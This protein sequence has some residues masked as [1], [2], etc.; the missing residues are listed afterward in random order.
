[1]PSS[2]RRDV[3]VLFADISG[4]TAM[5]ERLDPEA[6]TDFMNLCFADLE[7]VVL[8]HGGVVDKFI[9]DCVLAVFPR[10]RMAARA[11]RAAVEMRSA[12][13]A[14]NVQ[15]TL[16]AP[17]DV[18]IGIA[19]G[20]VIV[21]EIGG[22]RAR[23][24]TVSG[25][26]VARADRLQH[27]A[28]RGEI[29]LCPRTRAETEYEPS[30]GVSADM[31]SLG[32]LSPAPPGARRPSE[33]RQATVLFA[34]V[35]GLE[36]LQPPRPPDE[37]TAL[38][39]RCF[40]LADT[41]VHAYGGVV[42]KYIGG[43]VM[44]LF[45]VPNAIEHAPR[46]AI[47]AAIEM[48]R[49][50]D[51]LRAEL[52]TLSVRIGINTGLVIA[53]EIG[54]RQRRDFT[55]MGDTVNL[56]SRLKDA[57]GE[58]AILVGPETERATGTEFE[59][60]SPLPLKLKGKERP[61]AVHELNSA[62]ERVHRARAAPVG[63]HSTL[64]GRER[65]LAELEGVVAR[66]RAGHGGIVSVIGEAGLGKSRLVAE[67]GALEAKHDV[68]VLEG[69]CVSVGQGLSFHPFVD[70]LRHWARIDD[71]AEDAVAAE[72]LEAAVQRLLPEEVDDVFPFLATLMGIRPGGHHASRIDGLEGEAMEEMIFRSVRRLLERLAA[73]RPLLVLFEDLHWA[74]LS[75]VKLLE[76]LLRLVP[77]H[78]LLFTCVGRPDFPDT[79]GRI[80][81]AARDEYRDRY[82]E[83]VLARLTEPQCAAIVENLLGMDDLPQSTRALIIRK[84][85]G[86]PF[87]LEEVIRSL[88][89]QG[90]LAFRDGRYHRTEKIDSVVIPETIQEV[91]L[92][93]VDRLDEPTR[94]VLQLASVI[95][96][97]FQ[98]RILIAILG[99]E[100]DVD[101]RLAELTERRLLSVMES[102]RTA[103]LRRVRLHPERE[104]VFTHALLQETIYGAILQRTRRQL[105]AQVAR[106]TEEEFADR[107]VDFY[108]ML[109][110]HYSRAEH[111]EKAEEY[112]FKAGE[113][114]ARAAASTESL[115]FFREASRLYFTMHGEGGDPKKKALLE[116]SIGLA[117]LNHGDLTESIEH[118]DQAL[119]H[120]GERVPRGRATAAAYFARDLIGLLGQ[121]YVRTPRQREVADWDLEREVFQ[122][123]FNRGRAEITSDP[124][125]LFFDMVGGFRRINRIDARQ[126]DQAS[127]M[128]ASAATV[129]CY[130]GLSF[131]VSARALDIARRLIRPG[132]VRDTF[133]VASMDF[134]HHYLLGD[135]NDAH[136]ID[137]ELVEEAIRHGQLWDVNTYLGLHCDRL[138]RQGDFPR[139]R[140][141]LD[142]LHELDSAFGYTFAGANRD[143]MTA[144]VLTEERRLD[145][146][147]AAIDVYTEGRHEDALRVLGLG[148]R[149][150][151][152]ILSGDSRGAATSLAAAEKITTRSR[153]VPPWHLSA[154]AAA[155][156]R[157]DLA[158]LDEAR[159]FMPLRQQARRSMRYALRIA[160]SVAVQRTEIEQLA[161]RVLWS[162]GRRRSAFK[163]WQRAIATGE[164]LGARP[165]LART[166]AAIARALDA[167]TG[168]TFDG[169]DAAQ[170]LERARE[171][172]AGAGLA[173]DLEQE[174]AA[175]RA[176]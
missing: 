117:L 31:P 149:A 136:V 83:L 139:A 100:E 103:S 106:A 95:G 24:R 111:I 148:T 17:L 120:L 109:A 144:L 65:E 150:K 140:A 125:R 57:A 86:N 127:A 6:V 55:V 99:G 1:M 40:V 9:G 128:V 29:A 80:T 58:W 54:G 37:L 74:D 145:E 93:R 126:I 36:A 123:L 23:T 122:I 69:R 108:G 18:H 98:H 110:F 49:L 97:S 71:E 51:R 72:K 159:H 175:V 121:L 143:G 163:Q 25:D 28:E 133:T 14:L 38:M 147:L 88:V 173:W 162:L 30:L 157:C 165:E 67:L 160:A 170:C 4:F 73:E 44:A 89:E 174:P 152:Q 112:L 21:G 79:L 13:Q 11:A 171:L 168:L 16:P 50:L 141:L 78:S 48:R 32:L 20:P 90:A 102:R 107:L 130:S 153:E 92:S 10:A 81:T 70:L 75:S 43:C 61:V 5:S 85:D 114:A 15:H 26:T 94:H 45:G 155:R 176:A 116:K 124:T 42:D 82:L 156:L 59:Y 151:I 161:G 52:P 47:N 34:D 46:Q 87:Y 27:E 137:G 53:G 84:A 8:A 104:Y 12:I 115:N 96:R 138:L 76:S 118:F 63:V 158:A 33:R 164:R 62:R 135:W 2:E 56:A 77:D 101:A 113:E 91:I 3:S 131:A 119:S 22:E 146:A 134:I 172:F 167:G 129:F 60:A 39:N 64:V 169:V 68:T 105:H 41:A 154:Y 142:R 7:G 132:N 19:T 166:W 35:R 66:L